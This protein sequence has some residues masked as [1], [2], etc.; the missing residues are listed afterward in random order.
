M[1]EFATRLTGAVRR[2]YEGSAAWRLAHPRRM[3]AFC[4]GTGKS[5]THSLVG[6]FQGAY[7]TAHEPDAEMFI[8]IIAA[9]LEG[10]MPAE[11]VAAW[12]RQRDRRLWLEMDASLLNGS[13]VGHLVALFPDAR[14]ILTIRDCYSWL[15]SFINHI[16]T[17][18]ASEAWK[19]WRRVRY[20]PAELVYSR[21]EEVL[22]DNGLY[23]VDAY[24]R[25]W[26]THNK[27]VLG[28]V[29]P[30]RLL[31]V[32]TDRIGDSAPQ[33]A[34]FLGIPLNTIDVGQSHLNRRTAQAEILSR[35]D[36]GLVEQRVVEHCRELMAKYFPDI[37]DMASAGLF[38]GGTATDSAVKGAP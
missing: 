34:E 37:P 28:A 24:L 25:R 31:V 30:H 8:E 4:V 22:R 19:R 27:E 12:L 14:F 2:R 17:R 3:H 16:Q 10:R 35:V 26:A 32:R 5:G 13:V 9:E 23:P 21:G 20:A 7:R 36:P 11:A 15:D 1:I 33:M 38:P 18:K 6:M 29:P